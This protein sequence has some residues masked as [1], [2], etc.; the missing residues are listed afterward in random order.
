MV[1]KKKE[2]LRTAKEWDRPDT[3]WTD[4]SRQEDGAVGV[5]CVWRSLE[6]AWTGRRFLLGK[7]KEVFD[8]EVFAVW[9]A[10]RA[11]EQ[12]NERDRKYTISLDSTSDITRVREEARGPGKCLGVAATEV[13]TRLAAAGNRV[14]VRWVPAHAGAEGDEMA[15]PV[16]KGRRHRQSFL[17][18]VTRG[19]CG[20]DVLGP[21][22]EGRYRGQIQ[23]NERVDLGARATGAKLQTASWEW[24]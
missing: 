8:A 19:V 6:G 3:L 23:G 1:E 18:E 5:A 24:R 11:L 17:R 7:N 22:D 13:G 14:T 2:A 10:L 15:R 16:C 4:G 12:R 9:Q 21:Y 20:G